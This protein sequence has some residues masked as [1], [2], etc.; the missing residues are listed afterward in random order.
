MTVTDGQKENAASHLQNLGDSDEETSELDHHFKTLNIER[1][2]SRYFGKSSRI[3][4]VQ[5]AMEIKKEFSKQQAGEVLSQAKRQPMWQMQ[6]QW[7]QMPEIHPEPLCF[8]PMDLMNNLIHLYFV[9]FNVFNPLLHRPTFVNSVAN[10][11]HLRDYFFGASLLAVCAL[12]A[13]YSNDPRVFYPG[14]TS[15]HSVGWRWIKQIQLMPPTFLYPASVYQLQTYIL[16]IQ[17]TNVTTTPEH[18]WLLTSFGIRL[19][20]DIGIHRRGRGNTVEWRRAFWFLFMSDVVVSQIVGRPQA[21]SAAHYDIEY[22]TEC[23]DEYWDLDDPNLAWKQPESKPSSVSCWIQML[24]LFEILGST[25]QTIYSV[26]RTGGQDADKNLAELDSR[27]NHWLNELPDHLKWDPNRQDPLFFQQS[28]L[29]YSVYHWTQIQV[30]RAFLPKL[31]RT[32]LS[33]SSSLVACASASRSCARVINDTRRRGYL[34]PHAITISAV[35]T[36]GM[37]LLI[38]AWMLSMEKLPVDLKAELADIYRCL[39]YLRSLESIVQVAGRLSDILGETV[40]ISQLE[41][42][43]KRGKRGW[44][45]IELVNPP[46][47]YQSSSLPAESSVARQFAGSSRV[48]GASNVAATTANP[49]FSFPL[50]THPPQSFFYTRSFGS[51]SGIAEVDDSAGYRTSSQLLDDF[52]NMGTEMSTFLPPQHGAHSGTDIYVTSGFEGDNSTFEDPPGIW[53]NSNSG[54]LQTHHQYDDWDSYLSTVNELL[55]YM[56][57]RS[58]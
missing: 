43:S 25:D 10:G 4:L 42:A 51:D 44:G 15:Q 3:M 46:H 26:K 18:A 40:G 39:D 9:Q 12:G 32:S 20:Q 45:F 6:H 22:P 16:V 35:F 50:Y 24:K 34:V 54:A 41:Q 58:H 48:S 19:C 28:V 17:F 13:R 53:G 52:I 1:T 5:T 33:G 56:E 27:L 8:P 2:Q 36:S 55:H 29:L 37:I 23:D 11:L 30:H 31:G 49:N 57:R 38:N 21:M 14:S 7:Q 47:S